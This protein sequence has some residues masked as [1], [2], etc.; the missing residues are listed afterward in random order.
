M[1][2]FAIRVEGLSKKYRIGERESSYRTLRDSLAAPFKFKG[3]RSLL[4]RGNGKRSRNS[5]NGHNTFWAL[6]DISFEIKPGEVVG[7]I[8]RN[9]AGKSTLLKILSRI[10]EP[11]LG[12]ADIK[13]R[14]GS[15]LEVGTG[16]HG[17]LTG[18]ENIYLN[19]AILG[20]R[21]REIERQFDDI[22]AFAEVEE[23]VDTPVKHYSTGMYLRLAFAV[24]AH[25]EPEI[26]LVD[27]VLAVG[28]LA[29]QK[30]C[31]GKMGEVAAQGR[32]V[33]FVSHNV[34]AIKELCSKC[35]VLKNGELDFR[36]SVAEGL[37]HYGRNLGQTD[38]E[39]TNVNMRGWESITIHSKSQENS[40][41]IASGESFVVEASLVL[42]AEI[43]RARLYCLIN[44]PNGT[45]VAHNFA[46]LG[47]LKISELPA[48]VYKVRAE[49]PAL[50][51]IP[52]IYT[53]YFKLIC[54]DS[55]GSEDRYES[56]RVM[57]D[58]TDGT[59][60]SAGKIRAMLIPPVRWTLDSA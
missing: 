46:D 47:D 5:R 32:T 26:L 22:V 50:W 12:Y 40:G 11:T 29:F 28:D 56:S 14:V 7:I 9:G 1:D 60:Q 45:S 18:R 27:E 58:I 57:L 55:A 39:N 31:L 42:P 13:G 44:D 36:G 43:R 37:L 30:K 51:L 21:G 49:V 52:N 54:N 3:A 10:T 24:A 4:G 35:I 41:Q 25:L 15:L 34:G 2:D 38:T 53:A 23:F 6:K 19:G 33:L 48:G 16:F 8:G 20:M 59:K 17:E